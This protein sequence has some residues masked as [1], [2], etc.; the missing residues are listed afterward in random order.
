MKGRISFTNMFSPTHLNFNLTANELNT[1]CEQIEKEYRARIEQ[2][3]NCNLPRTFQNT[4]EAVALADSI[5]A[6]QSA[7]CVLPSLVSEDLQTRQAS[8]SAKEKLAKMWTDTYLNNEL[9]NVLEQVSRNRPTELSREQEKLIEKMTHLFHSNGMKLEPEKRK[10]LAELRSEIFSL[11][12]KFCTNINEDTSVLKVR[13]EDLEG[14]DPVFIKSLPREG[15]LCL[16]GCK[17]PQILPVMQGAI[18][19]K[20]RKDLFIVSRSRCLEENK[21]LLSKILEKRREAAILLGYKSHVDFMLSSKMARDSKTVMDF[22]EDLNSKI[23]ENFLAERK[24]LSELKMEKF[25]STELEP[26]DIAYLI[27]YA[28]QRY[29]SLDKDHLKQF[30]PLGPVIS[31]IFSVYEEILGVSIRKQENATTWHSSVDVY[32]VS[33]SENSENLGFFFLDLFSRPGK[34]AH[35]CVFPVIPSFINEGDDQYSS[36]VR[37][38][39]VCAILGNFSQPSLDR[40]SLLSHEEVSTFFHEFGHVMHCVLSRSDYSLLSWSWPIVPWSGGVEQ[41]FLE[42]PSMM[43]ELW[44]Y[45]ENVLHRLSGHYL[46]RNNKLPQSILQN[47]AKSQH[48]LTSVPDKNYL[49]HAIYDILIHS[50]DSSSY[51]FAGQTDLDLVSLYRII[52]KSISNFTTPEN[53]FSVASWYHPCMGYD[54]GY[55]GYMWSE[56]YS[57]DLFS[58]F[59]RSPGG[60]F[61]VVQ[62]R[63]I[64]DEL[65]SSGA[66]KDGMSMLVTCLGRP[67]SAESYLES[68]LCKE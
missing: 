49:A 12:E 46:D 65:L 52:I 21:F 66:T 50:S 4:F 3:L 20:T 34:Y 64:R 36:R 23:D 48:F 68:I 7:T 24:L 60:C 1:K 63:K 35:Q 40:P 13:E 18:S 58:L 5:S 38:N 6:A 54:A 32:T 47:I 9:Y 11:S 45:Q 15:D 2:V 55:Y 51:S 27:N 43:F 41:D 57:Y 33:D 61:D 16:V 67:P 17:L 62:G 29:L 42:V 22:L 19:D 8:Q 25:G 59:K 14:V 53:T 31:E 10:L 28:K 26:W 37:V 30:F 39:S 56:V 44:M